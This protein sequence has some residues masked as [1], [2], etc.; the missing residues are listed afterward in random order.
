MTPSGSSW[1]SCCAPSP[2]AGAASTTGAASSSTDAASPDASAGV[3]GTDA[4][5]AAG[6]DAAGA[7]W[8]KNGD[9]ELMLLMMIHTFVVG[10]HLRS[11][12][13]GKLAF[14]LFFMGVLPLNLEKGA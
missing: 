3:A 4:A 11:S 13:D 2:A 8:M 10:I 5:G 14:S 7:A 9:R 1:R 12:L 6:T